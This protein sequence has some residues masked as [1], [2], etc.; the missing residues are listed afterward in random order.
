MPL[1]ALEMK[2]DMEGLATLSKD[3]KSRLNIQVRL[4]NGDIMKNIWVDPNEE[5]EVPGSRGTVNV[6]I[7]PKGEKKASTI[8]L[9]STGYPT[10]KEGSDW[11]TIA[12]L[13]C[14]GLSVESW[15]FIGEDLTATTPGGE[16]VE[17]ELE[18]GEYYGYDDKAESETSITG[19]QTRVSK[20]SLKKGKK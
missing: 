8:K 20:G 7:K 17:V 10:Y 15:E 18:D 3:Q 11:H 5:K 6:V 12:T 9:V 16:E 19:I 14:R 4:Q 2:C 1:F 13:D